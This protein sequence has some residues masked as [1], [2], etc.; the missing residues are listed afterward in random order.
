MNLPIKLISTDFDGTLFAEFENPPIPERLQQLIGDLQARGAKWAINTGREMSSLMEALA[1]AKIAVEPDY[2]VLVEREIH[3]HQDSRY[4]ALEDWNSACARAHAELFARVLP[5][6]PDII[7]WI[8]ARFHAQIYDDAYSPFCLIAGNNG[9]ADVI[10][11]YL[12]EYARKIPHLAVVR[13]D[14]YARFCHVA[15]N[16]GTALAELTRR[17]GL[18]CEDVFA[19]GDHLNDLPMLSRSYARWLA[20]PANAVFEVKD[21]VRRQEGFVSELP[22]GHGVA[23]ALA[24]CLAAPSR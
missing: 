21:A 12:N 20:A 10:H 16:K 15:Y 7:A 11:K 4:V 2:L 24:F 17:L 18:S 22:C 23:D 3:Q 6:L 19:T 13:N 14:V 5:Y 8:S 9:D 1:R